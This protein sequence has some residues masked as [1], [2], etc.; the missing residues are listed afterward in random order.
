MKLNRLKVR[1]VI[2]GVDWGFTNPG[3]INVFA[4]DGD[5]RMI[6][7]REHYHTRKTIDWWIDKAQ[8]AVRDLGVEV[9]VCDPAE[10]GFIQQFNDAGLNAIKGRNEILPGISSVAARLVPDGTGRFRLLMYRDALQERDQDL[11][12]RGLP[13]STADEFTSYVWPKT[14]SG[15][16][17]KD[18]PVD[19]NNHGMDSVRYPVMYLDIDTGDYSELDD[20][21]RLVFGGS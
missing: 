9:F 4:V 12:D 3:V 13:S 10:P 11:V 18:R 7:L 1:Q 20:Y 15:S 8:A 21:E 5:K 6:Q 19:E 14:S 16:I 2:A 17:Q